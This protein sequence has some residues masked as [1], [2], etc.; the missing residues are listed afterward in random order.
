MVIRDEVWVLCEGVVYIGYSVCINGVVEVSVVVL[1]SGE[2]NRSEGSSQVKL[3]YGGG[4]LPPPPRGGQSVASSATG[5][6]S[7]T[8]KVRFVTWYYFEKSVRARY[9]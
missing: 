3:V 9:T 7:K 4:P 8:S 5:S 6:T 1:R 2:G